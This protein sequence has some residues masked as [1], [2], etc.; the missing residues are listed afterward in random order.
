MGQKRTYASQKAMSAL[1]QIAT[2]KADF[3][4]PSCPLYPRER[5]C[6][7]QLAVSAKGQKRTWDKYQKVGYRPLFLPNFRQSAFVQL[8]RLLHFQIRDIANDLHSFFFG[9]RLGCRSA[10]NRTQACRKQKTHGLISPYGPIADRTSDRAEGY[11]SKC[12]TVLLVAL[13][14]FVEEAHRYPG[15]YR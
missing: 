4:N 1:P 6:A 12:D 2:A 15:N 7:V 14:M 9:D 11:Q 10:R 3:S 8:Y 5:T 13:I